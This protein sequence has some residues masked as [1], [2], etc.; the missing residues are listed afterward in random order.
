M[1]LDNNQYIFYN[2]NPGNKTPPAVHYTLSFTTMFASLLLLSGL[3]GQP[4][5]AASAP[6]AIMANDPMEKATS[7]RQQARRARRARRANGPEVYKGTTAN[8]YRVVTEGG[9]PDGPVREQDTEDTKSGAKTTSSKRI[10]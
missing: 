3:L 4:A 9:S 2:F 7:R 1:I 8:L 6:A 10:K 5:F